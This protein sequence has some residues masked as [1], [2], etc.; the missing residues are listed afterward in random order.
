MWSG[1]IYT[2]DWPCV[3]RLRNWLTCYYQ[4]CK[5]VERWVVLIQNTDRSTIHVMYTYAP[6][7]SLS[8]HVYRV[9]IMLYILCQ[10]DCLSVC[11]NVR[12]SENNLFVNKPQKTRGPLLSV[13]SCSCMC[14]IYLNIR[15]NSSRT[16]KVLLTD[17]GSAIIFVDMN[18]PQYLL[19]WPFSRG[20]MATFRWPPLDNRGGGGGWSFCQAFFLFYKGDGKL[21]FFTSG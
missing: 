13:P 11:L 2:T 1:E 5:R 21:Y 3:E 9:G 18:M 6:T 12:R 20:G 16:S 17:Y 10:S 7:Q 14:N 4:G 15:I 19:W 8:K